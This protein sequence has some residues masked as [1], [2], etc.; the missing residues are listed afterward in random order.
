VSVD[1]V[2]ARSLEEA[3]TALALDGAPAHV[4]AGGTDLM[5]EL[6]TGRTKPARVVDVWKLAELRGRRD[7]AG[8]LRL[9]ALTTCA[10]LARDPH[11][12]E[13]LPMLSA[14][15]HDVGAEQIQARATLGGNLGTASP[16]G[17]LSV[18]L[19]ALG[20]RVR[21]VSMRG[22]RELDVEEFLCGYRSTLRERDELI[23]SILI[24]ARPAGE[25]QLWRKLGT[26]R[27]QSISKVALAVCMAFDGG[28]VSA[29]RAAAGAVGPRILRL[30]T[31]EQKL[32][33]ARVDA[34]LAREVGSA[35]ARGDIA[36]IDD[37]RSTGDYRRHALARMLATAI[38]ELSEGVPC[39][40]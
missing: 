36:P 8:G 10:E 35:C 39:R 19:V 29:V 38:R 7:E 15:A 22:A 40:F 32:M 13:R 25:R 14:V 33:G 16:A 20:A 21:L 30:G 11:V 23:E 18:A 24:P 5:V 12:A 4:L 34:A 17:D 9:G 26:R 3:L 1:Y 28:R 2:C 27:A 31:L 37:V 6:H